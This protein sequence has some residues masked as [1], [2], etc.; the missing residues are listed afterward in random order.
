MTVE[1][2][3]D[4]LAVVATALDLQADMYW[5]AGDDERQAIA[6]QALEKVK[7]EQA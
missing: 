4:E 6:E 5:E 2:T 3:D 7:S 1:F